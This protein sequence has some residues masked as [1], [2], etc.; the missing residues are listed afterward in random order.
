MSFA[1]DANWSDLLVMMETIERHIKLL[2]DKPV[3]EEDEEYEQRIMSGVT[4]DKLP[5]KYS[6]PPLLFLI[7]KPSLAA[8]ANL[9]HHST[10]HHDRCRQLLRDPDAL[11]LHHGSVFRGTADGQQG[12]ARV[13]RHPQLQRSAWCAYPRPPNA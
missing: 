12:L 5:L 9:T 4:S 8:I 1:R 7:V 11:L 13:G 2:M 3:H 10:P 6:T